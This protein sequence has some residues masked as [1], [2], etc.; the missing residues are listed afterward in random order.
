MK[1]AVVLLSG[2]IDSA[3]VLA[4]VADQGFDICAIS[5][6][7]GQRHV[8]EL[9]KAKLIAQN[10]KAVSEHRI[11]KIDLRSIGGSALTSDIAVPEN[12]YKATSDIP[13]TYV[14]ARNTIFLSFALG[15]AEV[16]VASDI[17]IG[18]NIVD[19]SNYPDCRPEYLQAFETMAQLATAAGN[20]IKIHA[21]LITLSKAAIIKRGLELGVNYLETIS[22][23][24]PTISGASCGKCDSCI[25]RQK[26][27]EELNLKDPIIYV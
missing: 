22:C 13:V 3:T 21:P 17:F 5:F 11:I 1:K 2:G 12:Q 16:I 20:K 23:Y 27:F 15:V 4:I 19:Y 14:P 24:N 8:I 18:A 6:D 9:T 26:A 25:I 7:Y 10:N